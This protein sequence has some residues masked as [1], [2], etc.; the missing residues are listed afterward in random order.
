MKINRL[1]HLVLTVAD[2]PRTVGFYTTVLG[3]TPQTFGQGRTALL[4]GQHKINLHQA[5]HE[6]EP[7]AAHPT[8]GSADLCL[9]VEGDLSEVEEHLRSHDVPIIEGIV[10]RT[11]AQGPIHSLYIRDPDGN[12]IELSTYS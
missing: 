7:K 10:T 2:I 8:P 12:L 6:I 1:D 9:I 3:V 5:G 11:G 4:F